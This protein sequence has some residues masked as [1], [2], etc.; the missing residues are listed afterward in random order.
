MLQWED[1]FV[2]TRRPLG[3]L[4]AC[5]RSSDGKLNSL[6]VIQFRCSKATRVRTCVP[7]RARRR[8]HGGAPAHCATPG[9]RV[10]YLRPEAISS[11]RS[12]HR[13]RRRTAGANVDGR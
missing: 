10:A 12:G 13:E 11:S 9:S 2:K 1:E 8:D 3:P 5:G 4:T 7:G 6:Y